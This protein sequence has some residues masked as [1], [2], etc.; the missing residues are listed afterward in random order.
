MAQQ[1]DSVLALFPHARGVFALALLGA[2]GL[3]IGASVKTR[4][5]TGARVD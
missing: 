5:I 4:R 1:M 3:A 2:L